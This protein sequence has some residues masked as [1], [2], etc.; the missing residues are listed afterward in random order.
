MTN[1]V[2]SQK[3]LYCQYFYGTATIIQKKIKI[4][5]SCK[6]GCDNLQVLSDI[7][8]DENSTKTIYIC[9]FTSSASF[10]FVNMCL[11]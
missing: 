7:Y 4:G 11:F 8:S 3:R 10:I 2:E 9:C 5:K 6:T 1:D